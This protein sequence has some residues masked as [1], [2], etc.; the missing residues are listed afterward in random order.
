MQI[1]INRFTAPSLIAEF[2]CFEQ[3]V[4]PAT[5][6][7]VSDGAVGLLHFDKLYEYLNQPQ[8]SLELIRSLTGKVM[9]LSALIH[10]ETIL[11]SEAKVADLM[12]K[13]PSVF[14][15]LKNNEIASI[16]TKFK[17]GGI[18]SV[19]AHCLKVLNKDALF[20]IVE[21]NTMKDCSNC[22]VDFKA[23]IG[24]KE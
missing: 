9:M 20:H 19:E 5:C 24:Y 15:R 23:K 16:L 12:I 3:E 22:I 18:I 11:S 4:F 8:F 2:A 13:K 6:E 21:T 7:F 17:K 1:Q 14:N 10:K